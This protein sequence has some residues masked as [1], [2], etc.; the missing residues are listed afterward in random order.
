[1]QIYFSLIAN[2]GQINI[3]KCKTID[4]TVLKYTGNFKRVIQN[5]GTVLYCN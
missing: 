1:M 2:Y 5:N 3:C 4:I